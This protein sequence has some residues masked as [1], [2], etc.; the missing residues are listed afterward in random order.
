MPGRCPW[1]SDYFHLWLDEQGQSGF[2]W[3]VI[4]I[5]QVTSLPMTTAVTCPI[6]RIHPAV[7][8]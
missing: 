7:I 2:V 4:A 8:A 6:T 3:S 1:I 5:S